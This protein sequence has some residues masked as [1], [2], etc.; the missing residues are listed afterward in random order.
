M[1]RLSLEIT[2]LMDVAMILVP[3]QEEVVP[4]VAVEEAH[5]LSTT[6]IADT[7]LLR[8]SVLPLPLLPMG[9]DPIRTIPH[10]LPTMGLLVGLPEA[11]DIPLQIMALLRPLV[12]AMEVLLVVTL[13]LLLFLA[14]PSQT[15]R[16]FYSKF[17]NC[18]AC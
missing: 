17:L 2:I 14:P 7:R 12:A 3:L 5:K 9:E 16:P 15:I 13:L 8:I 4:K 6:L 18:R 11:M 1:I 10:R